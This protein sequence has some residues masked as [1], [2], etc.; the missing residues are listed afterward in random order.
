MIVLTVSVAGNVVLARGI[1]RFT[2]GISDFRPAFE[3]M[4]TDFMQVET[5]QFATEGGRSGQPWPPLSPTYAA[6]KAKH[7]PGAPILQLTRTMLAQLSA[8]TGM[9]I[10]MQPMSLRMTPLVPWAKWHQTG[11]ARMPARPPVV[12]TET[13]KTRWMKIL[14]RYVYNKAKEAGL[15]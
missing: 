12:L 8:G 2:E 1:E 13:D 6:W 11:T 4:R 7:Y 15:T 3:E 5:E 14:H 9:Q 10:D